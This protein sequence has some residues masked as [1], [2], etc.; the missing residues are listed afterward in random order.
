[1]K[2]I[3][4]VVVINY[5]SYRFCPNIQVDELYEELLYETLHNVGCENEGG[6]C[7]N[8]LLAYI[9]DAFKVT[10]FAFNLAKILS[11]EL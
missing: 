10:I 2:T 3:I 8:D 1:M 11:Q 4:F 5:K 6:T 7:N 9:Q